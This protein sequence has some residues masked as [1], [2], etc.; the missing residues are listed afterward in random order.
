[1]NMKNIGFLLA[2]SLVMI[3]GNS[4]SAQ[5][6]TVIDD[7]SEPAPESAMPDLQVVG[8]GPTSDSV[9]QA[10]LGSVL[11]GSRE[12]ILELDLTNPLLVFAAAQL[13]IE[14]EDVLNFMSIGGATA[15]IRYSDELDADFSCVGGAIGIRFVFSDTTASGTLTLRLNGAETS[16][17]PLP[18]F[19]T[20]ARI[21]FPLSDFAG[22][23]LSNVTSM[24]LSAEFVDSS[25]FAISA[26]RLN[27]PTPPSPAP[28]LGSFALPFAGVLLSGIGG[29][30]LARRRRRS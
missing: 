25:D 3:A 20:A 2:V 23:D 19:D 11:G 28:A 14:P 22:T 9:I 18:D 21:L 13:D 6:V 12:L 8:A 1:M 24:T 7:F 5:T 27:C 17:Q 16:S 29:I 30:A 15:S 4:V 26:I 10:G